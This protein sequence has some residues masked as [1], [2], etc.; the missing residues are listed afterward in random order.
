V[1]LFFFT[2]CYTSFS[3]FVVEK[4]VLENFAANLNTLT[5]TNLFFNLTLSNGQ[6]FG[7]R[8]LRIQ[9]RLHPT[10]ATPPRRSRLKNLH[11]DI[12][13]LSASTN[14]L[15]DLSALHRIHHESR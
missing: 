15:T 3:R 14:A 11:V 5:S 9:R 10:D 6:G 1:R 7:D 4:A 12:E 13:P 8:Y 2:N